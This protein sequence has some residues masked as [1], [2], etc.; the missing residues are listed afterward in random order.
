LGETEDPEVSP[1]VAV[2]EQ[3]SYKSV[4]TLLY[5]MQAEQVEGERLSSFGWS[6]VTE[7]ICGENCEV[8]VLSGTLASEIA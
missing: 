5:Y 1:S 2:P 4:V 7:T 6:S 3:A 8:S